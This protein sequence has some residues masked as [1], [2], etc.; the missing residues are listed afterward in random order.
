MLRIASFPNTD[1]LNGYFSEVIN[2]N[3]CCHGNMVSLGIM[4]LPISF[5][6]KEH[7]QNMRTLYAIK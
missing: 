6:L 3:H 1:I 4:Q 2:V 5:V 7:A